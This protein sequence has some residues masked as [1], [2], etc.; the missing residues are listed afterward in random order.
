M[1]VR[2]WPFGRLCIA[3]LTL[4]LST[5]TFSADTAKA[6][7]D[8]KAQKAKTPAIR[9]GIKNADPKVLPGYD[10]DKT[11]DLTDMYGKD[12]K[13]GGVN[14]AKACENYVP[15][16]DAYKNQEC[17]TMN[18]VRR[19]PQERPAFVIDRDQDPLITKG[20]LISGAPG[21]HVAGTAAINGVEAGACVDTETKVPKLTTTE[22]CSVGKE[23]REGYCERVLQVTYV[24]ELY[25]G[26]GT[27][28]LRYG[29]CPVDQVRGDKLQLPLQNSFSSEDA[30]CADH[31]FGIGTGT[32]HSAIDC[33]GI[34][35]KFWFDAAKCSIKNEPLDVLPPKVFVNCA[36]A[37][38][39]SENCFSSLGKFQ[40]KV[41]APVFY[42]QWD[43]NS[44]AELDGNPSKI[45]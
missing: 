22:R 11:K 30:A 38:R 32:L 6:F 37:P 13:T 16:D 23:V 41:T 29:Y 25:V 21:Q 42:D 19:N 10:A 14:K 34:K 9:E 44:C 31:G 35:K 17:G 2:T 20:T 18:F 43:S 1:S 45:E 26:Q 8:G 24:M 27:A 4:A 7:A 36:D 33:F 12:I 28:D 3:A 5:P 15:G 40:N 39:S